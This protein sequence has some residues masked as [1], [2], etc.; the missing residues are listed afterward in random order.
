MI[1][2][3]KFLTFSH[4][5]KIFTIKVQDMYVKSYYWI[6]SKEILQAQCSFYKIVF[7]NREPGQAKIKTRQKMGT[8]LFV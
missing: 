8:D 7:R 4:L 3:N 1:Y 2:F 6:F 5:N